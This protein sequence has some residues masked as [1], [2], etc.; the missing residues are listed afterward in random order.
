M[1]PLEAHNCIVAHGDKVQSLGDIHSLPGTRVVRSGRGDKMSPRLSCSHSGGQGV[2]AAQGMVGQG[3][4]Q[5]NEVAESTSL[6]SKTR[7]QQ[8]TIR[9]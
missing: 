1:W 2:G 3:S 5:L 4:L 7:Q 8:L 9:V 6:I